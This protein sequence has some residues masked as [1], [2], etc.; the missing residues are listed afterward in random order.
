MSDVARHVV[1]LGATDV[2][3]TTID[4]LN[5]RWSSSETVGTWQALSTNSAGGQKLS[6]GSEIIGGMATRQEILIWTDAGIV[7]MRYVGSPF[8]FSFTEVA[9]GAI[10]D[11]S[12]CSRQCRWNSLL[13]GSWSIL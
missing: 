4:P 6:S 9:R 5:V 12:K 7:S 1:C 11:F 13:H 10:H 3:S 2:N 8:Y